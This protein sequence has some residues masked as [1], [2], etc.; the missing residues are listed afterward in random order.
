MRSVWSF[1]MWRLLILAVAFLAGCASTQ[2]RYVLL[3][4]TYAPLPEGAEVNIVRDGIPDRPFVRV[5]RLDV[6]LERTHFIGSDLEDALPELRRQARLSGAEAIIE[7]QEQRS[8]VGET[9]I[10]HVTAVGVRYQ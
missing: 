5:S 7:I 2:S 6:H 1:P 10:Y 8:Q 4:A 9:K 3:G